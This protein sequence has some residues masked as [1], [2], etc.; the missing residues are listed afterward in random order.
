MKYFSLLFLTLVLLSSP[1]PVFAGLVSSEALAQ[2]YSA[3]DTGGQKIR[4]LLV[5][6][7]DNETWGTEFRGMKEVELNRVVANNLYSYFSKDPAFEVFITQKDGEYAEPFAT[8]L[9]SQKEAIRQFRDSHKAVQQARREKGEVVGVSGVN[10]N[11]ASEEVSIKLHG[12]NKWA[13]ENDIDI[14]IHIHFNDHAGRVWNK[15]GEHSGFSIYV[16]E[17]QL[18]NSA[19]S[20]DIARKVSES[21]APFSAFSSL[22]GEGGGVID[23]QDLIAIGPFN[24]LDSATMLI[25]YAYIYE[26]QLANHALRE[27]VLE[28][29]AF[30]TYAGVKDFFGSTLVKNTSSQ[31]PRY[32]FTKNLKNG[33]VGSADVLMLQSALVRAGVYPVAG[34]DLHECPVSGTFGACTVASVR[35]FQKQKKLPVTG[36]VGAGTRKAL[37]TL[38]LY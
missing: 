38:N 8:Y 30:R 32:R 29:Y 19:V 11:Y 26:S 25:E 22:P 34:K 4:V 6:G 16:P 36:F 31:L 23:E 2:K 13:N 18:K 27:R 28:E 1:S 20:K 35:A 14:A 21:L 15:K 37:N 33:M 5:P 17:P 10:H 12:I 3:T 9:T 7:H 24:T